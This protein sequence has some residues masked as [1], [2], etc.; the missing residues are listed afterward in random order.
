MAFSIPTLHSFWLKVICF[1]FFPTPTQSVMVP[2]GKK[3]IFILRFL[4]VPDREF[5][6]QMSGK[7]SP[8]KKSIIS[9]TS[10]LINVL[11][12]KLYKKGHFWEVWP[13]KFSLNNKHTNMAQCCYLGSC[14]GSRH[15]HPL[16]KR[17]TFASF[18]IMNGPWP[19]AISIS[20]GISLALYIVFQFG[21]AFSPKTGAYTKPY[22]S[23]SGDFQYPCTPGA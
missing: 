17:G 7:K 14:R 10:Q 6:L 21:A 1:C 22:I 15:W 13:R 9:W 19:W 11:K 18:D 20:I 3:T 2:Q 23:A 5:S 4:Q 8:T 12:I 16:Q